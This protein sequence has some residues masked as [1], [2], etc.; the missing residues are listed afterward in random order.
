[1]ENIFK[2][3]VPS[4]VQTPRSSLEKDKADFVEDE[5]ALLLDKDEDKDAED[6]DVEES[7][8]MMDDPAAR[9]SLYNQ[10]I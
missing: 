9:K 1:M 5:N 2:K 8:K 3:K 6:T 4:A 10:Q 7:K